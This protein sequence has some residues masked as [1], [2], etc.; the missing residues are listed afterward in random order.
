MRY[1][2]GLTLILLFICLLG[3]QQRTAGSTPTP[4]YTPSNTPG[5][6]ATRVVEMTIIPPP[7]CGNV[8]NPCTNLPWAIPIFPT[9]DLPSPTVM[10]TNTA[11]PITT[12]PSQTLTP[13]PSVTGATITPTG[14]IDLGAVQTLA[15][16]FYNLAAT[17][18]D[19]GTAD[20]YDA[21]GTPASLSGISAGFSTSIPNI[22]STV[23]GVLAATNNRAMSIV[24][25]LF[26]CVLF[27]ILVYLAGFMFPVFMRIITFILEIIRT[28]KP[29]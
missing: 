8:Y 1:R 13:T 4:T 15:G 25:F 11:Q 14:A 29:F 7:Q 24:A 5:N 17:M 16:N 2:L 9:I 21:S 10:P 18:Q 26:I 28:F 6:N 3:Q 22:F 20:V 23:R 12:T 27:V 19:I